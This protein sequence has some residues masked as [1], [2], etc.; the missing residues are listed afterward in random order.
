MYGNL[1]G[2]IPELIAR[3][4]VASL[5]RIYVPA[6]CDLVAETYS[7]DPR[8]IR[9]PLDHVERTLVTLI[10]TGEDEAAAPGIT[11]LLALE[12]Q[13]ADNET[14]QDAVHRVLGSVGRVVGRLLPADHGFDFNSPGFGYLDDSRSM[15]MNELREGYYRMCEAREA[16]ASADDRC[17][18]ME[19]IE[20]TIDSLL[21]RGI[22]TGNYGAIREHAE[23]LLVD[24]TVAAASLAYAGCDRALNLCVAAIRS[25][26]RLG[27]DH[28]QTTLWSELAEYTVK[29]GMVAQ[30]R[31]IR[32][33][34]GGNTADEAI[35][36]LKLIPRQ[37]W[38]SAIREAQ[39][40]G[41][42]HGSDLPGHDSRWKF[43]TRAGVKLHTNF[44]MMFD[45][46]TGE[47]YADD[48]PR[49]G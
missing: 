31:D 18:W 4:G 1:L 44:G 33:F 27:L 29:L 38:D 5:H 15:A 22:A 12:I 40:H 39:L 7:V 37:Y 2:D 49:R 34:A 41:L 9:I 19:A 20:V 47:L 6:C 28:D 35:E 32:Y 10:M 25:F 3:H 13:F 42:M 36:V 26:T 48:D 30:D 24:L 43:I 45:A 17:L 46:N 8:L 16:A 23:S 11:A 14:A 21:K